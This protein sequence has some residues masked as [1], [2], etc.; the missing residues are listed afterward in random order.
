[1]SLSEN[2][3]EAFQYTALPARVLFGFGT[4]AKV[5]DELV[6]MG[7]KRAFV[8]TD[9]H[10][11]TA[12][13]ARLMLAL[14]E[15]GVQLS[16]DAVMHTPADVTERVMEKLAACD[17]DCIVA[18][19]GGSTI[20]L[21]KALA[22]RTDLPQIVLPTT[23]AGSEAT[24]VLGE[25]RDGQ[26]STIRSMQVLPEVIVYDVELT[27]GLPPAISLVSGINAIAHAVEALYAKDANPI[28]SSLAEQG[29]AALG[30]ALP[31][32]VSNPA[33]RSARADALFGAWVCGSCLGAVGMSLHH[34]LCHV[35][36]GTFSLPHAETHTVILPHAVAYNAAGASTAI[37]RV[38][39][40]L[41]AD[42]A[43]QALFDLAVTNG[44]P[45]SLR[46]IGMSYSDLDGATEAAVK[47]PYWNPRPVERNAIRKLLEDA[48]N[49]HRPL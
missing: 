5:A 22:L 47:S 7:R 46:E 31:R 43:A 25:T 40:A 24:P 37:D 1:M 14:G 16:T 27:Y 32:I 20:G 9:P 29:I 30:R 2:A 12:A 4:I 18:L 19:G 35:L 13:A 26:K 8:L 21:A 11:A 36:G 28:M 49:G 33:D 38:A 44:G 6:S 41:G 15:F 17:A 10:H 48:Y 23:Y 34:K 42:H 3:M 39:R 45:R